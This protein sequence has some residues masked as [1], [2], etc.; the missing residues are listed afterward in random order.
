MMRSHRSLALIMRGIQSSS[1]N[2]SMDTPH[3]MSRQI[4]NALSSNVAQ[5]DCIPH[6]DGSGTT[7]A[8][9]GRNVVGPVGVMVGIGVGGGVGTSSN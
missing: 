4:L 6:K 1:S 9:V 5:S 7:G 3:E 2:P 8:V